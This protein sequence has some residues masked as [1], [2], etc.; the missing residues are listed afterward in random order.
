MKK[1][2]LKIIVSAV[3]CLCTVATL[4]IGLASCGPKEQAEEPITVLRFTRDMEDGEKI[5]PMYLQEL[6]LLPSQVPEGTM[7]ITKEDLKTKF[8]YSTTHIFAGDYLVEGK[9]TEEKPTEGAY[10]GTEWITKQNSADYV[11][12]TPAEGDCHAALQKLID[13]NPCRTIYFPDGSYNISKPLVISSKPDKRVSLRF[14]QYAFIMVLD[15][16]SWKKG[17]ALIHYGKGETADAASID[18]VGARCYI[19]GGNL[20]AKKVADGIRLEGIGNIVIS[21]IA[22]K[23]IVKGIDVQTNNVDIDS[24]SGTG[25]A[26][27]DSIGIVLGGDHNSLANMRMCDMYYGVK[28][29]GEDNI[30]RNLHPLIGAALMHDGGTVAFW[31]LSRGNFY[32]Y[33]YGD[34]HAM[35]FKLCDGNTSVL[36]GCYSFWWSNANGKHWG[37]YA[38]GRFNSVAYGTRV[39]MSHADSADNAFIVVARDGGNGKLVHADVFSSSSFDNHHGDYNKYVQR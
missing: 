11:I 27:G 8:Y 21:H 22:L 13:D 5:A 36:N 19:S 7:A 9:V 29:T 1:A 17:D 25:N 33:C 4:C 15:A 28:L 26:T 23:N 6:S 18:G 24:F 38:D 14:S 31:D 32:D 37:I 2:L 34:Q 30:L 12:A 35:T 16:N 3:L 39:D 10:D 20:D